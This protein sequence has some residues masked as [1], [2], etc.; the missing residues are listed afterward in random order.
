MD[1]DNCVYRLRL[2]GVVHKSVPATPCVDPPLWSG[3]NSLTHQWAHSYLR[4]Y[5]R[6]AEHRQLCCWKQPY[7]LISLAILCFVDGL[8]SDL[9]NHLDNIFTHREHSKSSISTNT[10]NVSVSSSTLD[11]TTDLH[12]SDDHSIFYDGL[13]YFIIL[14]GQLSWRLPLTRPFAHGSGK[15]ST[16]LISSYTRRATVPFK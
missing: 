10:P 14:S 4:W 1:H 5:I 13:G 3:H 9:Y 2:D 8:R 16:S 12:E 15:S 6:R 11:L 7:K